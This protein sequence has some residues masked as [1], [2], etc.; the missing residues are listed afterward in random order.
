MHQAMDSK[1][2]KKATHHKEIANVAIDEMVS[3]SEMVEK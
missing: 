3:V 2:Y 1:D